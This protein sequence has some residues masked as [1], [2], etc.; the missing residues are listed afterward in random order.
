MV[1]GVWIFT[2][3]ASVSPDDRFRLYILAIY[4]RP[5]GSTGCGGLGQ[6]ANVLIP[7]AFISL[8]L[9]LPAVSP[10]DSRNILEDSLNTVQNDSFERSKIRTVG[11]GLV[12]T[13]LLA[14][15]LSAC[16]SPLR[17]S[18]K[19]RSRC[20]AEE[21]AATPEPEEETSDAEEAKK[22][23]RMMTP[24]PMAMPLRYA[25]STRRSATSTTTRRRR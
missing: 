17:R 3:E 12:L 10:T 5:E 13:L 20:A 14:L 6:N 18:P 8:I 16:S 7:P 24:I 9:S 11:F 1:S 4:R 23:L 25:T 2:T 22:R 21:I 19:T 15:V